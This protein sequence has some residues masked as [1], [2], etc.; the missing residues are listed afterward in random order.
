MRFDSCKQYISSTFYAVADYQDVINALN[1]SLLK[2]S[3][4]KKPK[5]IWDVKI[6]PP[7][8]ELVENKEYESFSSYRWNR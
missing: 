8:V 6:D 2:V 7:V 3:L 5:N 1:S 4:Y